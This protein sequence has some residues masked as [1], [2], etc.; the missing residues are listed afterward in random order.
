MFADFSPTKKPESTHLPSAVWVP[1]VSMCRADILRPM[2]DMSRRELKRLDLLWEENKTASDMSMFIIEDGEIG[3]FHSV[4]YLLGDGSHYSNYSP[5]FL[6]YVHFWTTKDCSLQ[7]A[8]GTIISCALQIMLC[9]IAAWTISSALQTV[10]Q[11][12]VLHTDDCDMH[13]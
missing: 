12:Y 11:M 6:W 3:S 8:T 1:T 4:Q 7:I 2:E 13:S 9:L 10:T 5:T